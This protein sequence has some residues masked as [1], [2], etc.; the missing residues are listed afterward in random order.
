[1][2]TSGRAIGSTGAAGR[3]VFEIDVGWPR[4]GEPWRSDAERSRYGRRDLV[5]QPFTCNGN[6][7]LPF[8]PL[9][10]LRCLE[11]LRRQVSRGGGPAAE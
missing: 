11:Q 3:A 8:G 10:L 5:C 1:M 9:S 7:E 2:D 4:P 6:E